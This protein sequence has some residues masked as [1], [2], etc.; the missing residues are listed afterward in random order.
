VEVADSAE[1]SRSAKMSVDFDVD[2]VDDISLKKES[3][4][5]RPSVLLWSAPRHRN[6]KG[7]Q[8]YL[9]FEMPRKNA[10]MRRYNSPC[11]PGLDRLASIRNTAYIVQ[12]PP[13]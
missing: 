13:F 4:P 9:I 12:D 6:A 8:H 2:A 10:A 5:V 7:S 3:R 11:D 1:F